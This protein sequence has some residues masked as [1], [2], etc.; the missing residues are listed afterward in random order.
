[1]GYKTVLTA[2]V[3]CKKLKGLSAKL[4]VSKYILW[5]LQLI[6]YKLKL[7]PFGYLYSLKFQ[8]YVTYREMKL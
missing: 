2:E 1:M 8:N 4:W 5:F 3:D 6:Y 7:K